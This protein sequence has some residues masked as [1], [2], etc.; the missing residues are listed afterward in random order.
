MW[1]LS[2]RKD[3]PT[4]GNDTNNYVESA[5]RVLKDKLLQC[6]MAYNLPQLFHLLTSRLD[7]YYKARLTNVA[8][9]RWDAVQKSR[10]LPRE[11]KIQSSD[12]KQVNSLY[13]SFFVGLLRSGL[14]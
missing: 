11:S 13:A 14:F 6:T 3:L 5:I 1:A 7:V 9:G 12:I 2:Y 10:F 8:L 4:R